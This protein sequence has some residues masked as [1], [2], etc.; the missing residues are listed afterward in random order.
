MSTPGGEEAIERLK[1]SSAPVGK[2]QLLQLLSCVPLLL[3][4]SA[5]V[6]L[7]VLSQD[8]RRSFFSFFPPAK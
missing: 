4:G 7:P 2:N 1:V 3:L 5:S 8:E 6:Y